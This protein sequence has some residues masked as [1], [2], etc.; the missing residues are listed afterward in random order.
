[1]YP[2]FMHWGYNA[3]DFF[4]LQVLSQV[5][6]RLLVAL[7]SP[8]LFIDLFLNQHLIMFTQLQGWHFYMLLLTDYDFFLLASSK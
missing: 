3:L 4:I 8:L 1:M 7:G 2:W 5:P 6:F